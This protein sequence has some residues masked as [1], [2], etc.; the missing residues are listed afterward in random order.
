MR[1]EGKQTYDCEPTLSDTEVLNFVREGYLLLEGVVI[2]EVNAKTMHYL[3]NYGKDRSLIAGAEVPS[4][5]PSEI[6]LEE[7]FV[8]GVVTCPAV[9]GAVRSLLGAGFG[10]PINMACHRGD[11]PG[12]GQPFH[13]DGDSQFTREL[14]YLQVFYYPHDV[15]VRTCTPRLT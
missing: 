5:E 15:T 4:G 7:W 13:H 9:A 14:N 6:L 3:Q 10:L 1:I 8:D 2:P 12:E 11:C